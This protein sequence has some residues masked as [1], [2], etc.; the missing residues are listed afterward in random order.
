MIYT[1]I[2]GG[3]GNQLFQYSAARSLAD[4]LNVS[5]GLDTREFDE[6]SPYK[7]SL[8][9]FNIRADLNPPDLIKHKK[10]GKIAYIIDHIKGNQKK[11]YKEPFLSFDKNLFSNVDGTYLKGYWQSEK[12]FLRNRKNILSDINLIKK[13]DKFNTINLKEIKKSTSISLHIRRGDYLSNESYN[14]THGICSL[15][16][17]TDAVEYIKNR[18]GENIKVFAFSDDPDWVLEN[19]K[20]SVDIKI[21]NNNTSANSFEDLRLMLNCDHNIIANSSFSWWGAWLNQNPEKIVISPKKWYNKKQLQ[22]ADIVPSSWLK[23]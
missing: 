18:L 1:R 9:H 13:T 2:R 15:S 10:D 5:L 21:I 23:Y 17:Y 14:E 12:Y 4:Y 16:Y 8:N 11:V 7:M 20:L 22:N 3:L 19:L 6:N